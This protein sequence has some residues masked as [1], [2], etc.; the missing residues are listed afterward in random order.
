VPASEAGAIASEIREISAADELGQSFL[1]YSLSVITAR[2]LPDV[3]D[4]L[5]PVQR[6]ILVAMNE[7]GLRPT[8]PH[9]KSA[10]VVGE[11]MGN[12]HPHGDSAIYEALVRLGQPFSLRVPLVD[13]HGNFGSLD[14]PPA[15]P[16]YTECR[17]SEAAMDVLAELDEDTVDFRSTYD[18]E[19]REPEYLP[20]RLPNLLVNGSSGIAVGMATNMAPHN[21][22]EVCR[23]LE[24]V[25]HH[26]SRPTLDELLAVLPGP[27]FPTGG[28][29]VD[30]GGL[31]DAYEAGRGGVRIRARAEIAQIT[32]RRRG[33]VVTEL[34]FTVGP[35]RVIARINE[36]VM[37]GKLTAITDVKDLTDRRAG[38]R[39]QI[40]CKTGADPAAVL[41]E[42][43]RLTPMED[44]FGIN[45]VVL[46]N[47]VPTTLGLYDLCRLYLEHRLDVVVR[48]T[49]F[50][51]DKA[52]DRAHMLEGLLV[53][54]DHIDRVIQII[55]GSRTVDV[56]RA[57]LQAAFSLSE[58]QA[59]AILNM[60]LRRLVA[61]ERQEL[62]DELA[63]LRRQI[64]EYED[65]LG[66]E[67]RRKAIVGDE[68][69]TLAEQRG[70]PRRTT[71][72]S[73]DDAPRL[74]AASAPRSL[75]LS[76]DPCVLTWST[77]GLVG[78][79][80]DEARSGKGRLGR[81]DVLVA[82]LH[83]SNR[84]QIWAVTDQGRA[85]A[86]T[87]H[88]VPEVSGRGR[89]AAGAELFPVVAGEGVVALLGPV[90]HPIVLLTA[91]GVA[92]RVGVDEVAAL[93]DGA[94]LIALDGDRLVAAFPAED[95]V[96]IVVVASDAQALRTAVAGIPV[97]GR[98][99]R[100]VAGMKLRAGARVLAAG[101]A[102]DGGV[103]LTVTDGDAAKLTSVGEI[104]RQGRA[105]AGVRLTKLRT[106]E[107]ALRSALVAP[108]SELW[109]VVGREDEPAKADTQPVPV[110]VTVTRRDAAGTRTA[111]RILAAGKARW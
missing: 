69:R 90:E 13:P 66:S 78:R 97:Q 57:E 25:L 94:T 61:L 75:E 54:L 77:S 46:V 93:R 55:R 19:G 79:E 59:T 84:Q 68:L 109:C 89:G 12:Y 32:A 72:V 9:R 85:L 10:K 86:I 92:K 73:G 70:T 51:L 44:S 82:D 30:D 111:R 104:P 1:P 43:Y 65:I 40:E 18:G 22:V 36:L 107:H 52:R 87:A 24:V 4:G 49:R 83:T 48:R 42:L 45:N 88:E 47:G 50:R 29:L 33:I 34:P 20:A 100:G 81:H 16:R 95:D 108:T 99:A 71:L 8:A 56:A 58:V 60:M 35:E 98:G 62:A 105:T 101:P 63:E 21:L 37:A 14:D 74:T 96:E 39:I 23:A 6:R 11:T 80:L 27:D 41:N 64:A 17:L 15:A 2:A 53:A 7:M 67:E 110:P 26:P 3:R 28:V 103:V 31:R 106:G 102:V 91:A 76:D 5:K 38:L